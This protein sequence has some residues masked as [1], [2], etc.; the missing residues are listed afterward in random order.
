MKDTG[1]REWV[2]SNF[3]EDVP[4]VAKPEKRSSIRESSLDLQ[5]GVEVKELDTVPAE[6]LELFETQRK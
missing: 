3:F 4:K 5:D 1:V 6:F 2:D